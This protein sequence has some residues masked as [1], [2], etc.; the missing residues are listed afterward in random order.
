MGKMRSWSRR[1]LVLTIPCALLAWAGCA[2]PPVPPEF[3]QQVVEDEPYRI[4]A[5]DVLLVRVWRNEELNVEAPVLPDGTV[6]IPLVGEVAARGLTSSELED[7]ISGKLVDYVATPEVTVT[8]REVRS[9]RASVVGEVVRSGPVN[10]A[11]RA[12]V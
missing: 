11:P 6:S 12:R 1:P 4:G 7:A 10:L 3:Q 2:T 8:V 9:K 5:S